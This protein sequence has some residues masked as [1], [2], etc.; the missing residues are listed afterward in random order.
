MDHIKP[1][2]LSLF[3]GAG[4]LDIGFLKSGFKIVGCIDNDKWSVMTLEKNN[5][6]LK[7]MG[8][9]YHHGDIFEISSSD[10]LNGPAP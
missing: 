1:K 6:K 8:P 4:G 2:V 10:I 3:S 7:I 9:P 5:P